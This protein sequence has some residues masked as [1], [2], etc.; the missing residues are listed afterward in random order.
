[1]VIKDTGFPL[2]FFPEAVE[3][4]GRAEGAAGGA[5]TDSAVR[6]GRTDRIELSAR[7]DQPSRLLSA[8]KAEISGDIDRDAD[9]GRLRELKESVSNGCYSVD[10]GALAGILL[11]GE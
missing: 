1:M 3:K 9:A 2:S 6:A 7:A 11:F 4:A 8:V 10:S 5:K